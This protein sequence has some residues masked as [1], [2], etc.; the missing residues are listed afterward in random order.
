M[1]NQLILASASPRR[2]KL[3]REAGIQ[4]S[5]QPADVDETSLPGELPEVYACRLAAEK[6]GIIASRYPR[7]L[8]LG[9]DTIVVADTGEI[10]EKP[11]DLGD[12]RRM[13]SL[14]SGKRHIVM[15][16]VSLRREKPCVDD[17]WLCETGVTFHS[18]R[19]ADIDQYLNRV[20]VLDKAGS[21]A[22]QECG[23]MLV[24]EVD[25]LWSNVVGLPVEEVLE[26]LRKLASI[27]RQAAKNAQKV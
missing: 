17:R 2:L 26:R 6:A 4:C 18:L 14:L 15:T 5:V 13:L 7:H 9:A 20:D 22:I 23:D 3:L 11:V 10:L 8:V 27:S 19:T 25:G 21:Y 24:A 1:S 16:G 12:A